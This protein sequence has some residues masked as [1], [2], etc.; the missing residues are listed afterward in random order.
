MGTQPLP[1]PTRHMMPHIFV[2]FILKK[3]MFGVQNCKSRFSKGNAWEQYS[4]VF[5]SL[6]CL[7]LTSFVFLGL[8]VCAGLSYFVLTNI[9]V[10]WF[11]CATD[12]LL[13]C[14]HG[15]CFGVPCM[16]LCY[17]CCVPLCSPNPA[18]QGVV[19]Y[20]RCLLYVASSRLVVCSIPHHTIPHCAISP[21]SVVKSACHHVGLCQPYAAYLV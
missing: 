21:P 12:A 18:M 16:T 8:F 7:L 14:I 20:H 9:M 2:N 4:S 3:I 17:V 10:L 1:P 5:P 13:F 6:T 15:A 19:S 11:V